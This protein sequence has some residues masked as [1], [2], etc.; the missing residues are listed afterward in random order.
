[1]NFVFIKCP[2]NLSMEFNVLENLVT[3]IFRCKK[4]H[5][6]IDVFCLVFYASFVEAL[7]KFILLIIAS[8]YCY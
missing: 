8:N 3:P 1:M 5:L 4:N 2:Q 7:Q 6:I